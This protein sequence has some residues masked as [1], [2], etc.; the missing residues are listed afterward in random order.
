MQSKDELTKA[1]RE[2]RSIVDELTTERQHYL[3]FFERADDA[4]LVT[5]AVGV[6]LEAN[7]AAV[8]L[9]ERRRYFLAGK[10]LSALVGTQRDDFRERLA[11]LSTAPAGWRLSLAV[12]G[13]A[14][15]VEVSTRPMGRAGESPSGICWLL[16]PV[17]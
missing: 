15:E 17:Q 13:R 2:L 4:Y 9:L 7:G 3:D 12:R 1:W 10:P 5:D 6:I 11:G 14:V 8:D 16:R